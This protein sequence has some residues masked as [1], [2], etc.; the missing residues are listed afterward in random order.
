MRF[1]SLFCHTNSVALSVLGCRGVVCLSVIS[2]GSF[3]RITLF[4]KSQLTRQQYHWVD[5]RDGLTAFTQAGGKVQGATEIAGGQRVDGLSRLLR[6]KFAQGVQCLVTQ[7]LG[8]IGLLQHVL[9]RATATAGGLRQGRYFQFGDVLQQAVGRIGLMQHVVQ[10]ARCV[11][12]DGLC[13]RRRLQI[14]RPV[15]L[16]EKL[17]D[18]FDFVSE[19]LGSGDLLV[20]E[21][22][23]QVVFAEGGGAAAGGVHDG[24]DVQCGEGV[25]ILFRE[26]CRLIRQSAVQGHGAAAALCGWYVYAVTQCVEQTAAG[27]QCRAVEDVGDAAGEQG[28]VAARF[29]LG[30]GG[31]IIA[32]G[33][34]VRDRRQQVFFLCQ[35]QWFQQTAGPHDFLQAPALI[36]SQPA[37][38]CWRDARRDGQWPRPR[39]Q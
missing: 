27:V 36:A 34:R 25:E 1:F 2:S 22:G 5:N 23:Q 11:Q 24:L 29:C 37:A 31:I 26:Q 38:R 39:F 3:N 12:G 33:W 19:D 13:Q 35:T 18:V 32:P 30:I 15:R 6:I 28:N 4:N 14:G 10:A 8:E 9:T 17:A 7:P 21:C 20:G 16:G